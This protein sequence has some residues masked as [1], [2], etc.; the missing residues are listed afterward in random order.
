M[1]PDDGY[2]CQFN[3]DTKS[4]W[5]DRND[6][7]LGAGIKAAGPR[8]ANNT[9]GDSDAGVRIG[10]MLPSVRHEDRCY[11]GGSVT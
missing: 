5:A 10:R 2:I 9:I 4:F 1:G 8:S 11:Y 3:R 7:L 6:L